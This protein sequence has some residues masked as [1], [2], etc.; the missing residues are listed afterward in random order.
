MG[1]HQT[2][3]IRIYTSANLPS[4]FLVLTP[5][6]RAFV[7]ALFELPDPTLADCVR[8][9]GYAGTG[10]TIHSMGQKLMHHQGVQAAMQAE[11]Y[12][13]AETAGPKALRFMHEMAF[14]R[15]HRDQYK[16]L[17]TVLNFAGMREVS[18]AKAEV[19]VKTDQEQLAE[20]RAIAQRLGV[21]ENH[22]VG[23]LTE[24]EWQEINTH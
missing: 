24:A 15:G 11:M 4:E 7:M 21:P 14:S 13:R 6:Q 10:Q 8:A 5:K 18:E 23:Q 19:I 2:D 12:R 20:L 3:I 9:A 17:R 22:F 16:A 1:S